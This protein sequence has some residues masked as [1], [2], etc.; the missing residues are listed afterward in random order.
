MREDRGREWR[1]IG[2]GRR[3]I[4]E[5]EVTWEFLKPEKLEK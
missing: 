2:D 1:R 3:G 4:N 5:Q